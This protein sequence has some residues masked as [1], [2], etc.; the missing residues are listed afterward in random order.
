MNTE[1]PRW[2]KASIAQHFST[3]FTIIVD[4]Q[5]RPSIQPRERFELRFDGPDVSEKL[6]GEFQLGYVVNLLIIS[7]SNEEDIYKMD[8]LKGRGADPFI[9]RIPIYKYGPALNDD[10]TL[11][12]CITRKSDIDIKDFGYFAD[13]VQHI[14][15]NAY[16]L[17]EPFESYSQYEESLGLELLCSYTILTNLN[18]QE[19]LTLGTEFN[20]EASD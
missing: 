8:R 2:I 11:I 3:F 4:G 17:F 1:W 15:I 13:N 10:G 12:G 7:A 6:Q 18:C 14:S 5:R 19:A 9:T 16:Y 20:L